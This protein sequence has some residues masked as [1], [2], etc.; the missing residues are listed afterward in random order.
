MQVGATEELVAAQR[1]VGHE[2]ASIGLVIAD[3]AQCERQVRADGREA[4]LITPRR[5]AAPRSG[6]RKHG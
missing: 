3:M 1:A 5:P 6:V 4:P 2:Q